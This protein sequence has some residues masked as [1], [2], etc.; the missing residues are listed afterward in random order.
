MSSDF[1]PVG[2]ELQCLFQSSGGQHEHISERPKERRYLLVFRAGS[3]NTSPSVAAKPQSA[4]LGYAVLRIPQ[5]DLVHLPMIPLGV[6]IDANNR[7]RVMQNG[8]GFIRLRGD[9]LEG[10]ILAVVTCLFPKL[11]PEARPERPI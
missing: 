9:T 1:V 4:V 11:L 3:I 2:T 7:R 6:R 5:E 8:L 10:E